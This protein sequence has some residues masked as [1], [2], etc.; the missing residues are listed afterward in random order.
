M[1]SNMAFSTR[2]KYLFHN[3]Y[4]LFKGTHFRIQVIE[5]NVEMTKCSVFR[6]KVRSMFY[7]AYNGYLENAY[8]LDELRPLTCKGILFKHHCI[9]S[10]WWFL[11]NGHLG[12]LLVNSYWCIGHFNHYGKSHRVFESRWFGVEECKYRYSTYRRLL[13]YNNIVIFI[14]DANVNVSVFE[15]NIRVVGGL[16][17]AHILSGRVKGILIYAY[18]IASSYNK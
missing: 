3:D 16:L 9:V 6:E 12:Q 13:V 1:D 2:A 17:S 11:R 15:T 18:F 4:R 14:V 10:T 7:H 8:P 5:C